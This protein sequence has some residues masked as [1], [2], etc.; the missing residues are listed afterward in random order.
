MKKVLLLAVL[1]SFVLIIGMIGCESG[2][3]ANSE[4]TVGDTSSQT[5]QIMN[6]SIG[7]FSMDI[8]GISLDFSFELLEGQ[9]PALVTS[10][11]GN[12]LAT[13]DT[14]Y[15]VSHSYTYANGWHIFNFSA[16]VINFDDTTIIE[17]LD[18]IQ[19]LVD[20]V[21]MQVPDSTM[22]GLVIHNQYSLDN[23]LFGGAVGHQ[24]L[25][26]AAD[27]FDSLAVVTASGN[28]NDS[29]DVQ[30][31]D[32]TDTCSLQI[33]SAVTINSVI[34]QLDATED[35]PT[36]GSISAN[37]DISMSCVGGNGSPLDSLSIEGSWTIGVAYHGTTA[38]VT[39]TNGGTSW[40]VID[41][42]G[43]SPNSISPF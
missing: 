31:A 1:A 29:I 34:F 35:C 22:N 27:S 37:Q 39:Y 11:F 41:S 32:E 16:T 3:P 9:F 19:T 7:S 25:N 21:P 23:N 12:Q 43:N 4:S 24:V 5:F 18:S 28:T 15:V 6:D 40:T 14:S 13:A 42:C 36:S 30:F 26:L 8:V 10:K 2:S 17:G 20:N 38:T 33:N